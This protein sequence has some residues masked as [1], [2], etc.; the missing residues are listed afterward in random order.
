[1][2]VNGFCNKIVM[3]VNGFCKRTFFIMLVNGFCK[4]FFVMFVE[5]DSV[6]MLFV[7]LINGVCAFSLGLLKETRYAC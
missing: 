4:S 6:N 5:L 7:M 2:R 3:C 1:M